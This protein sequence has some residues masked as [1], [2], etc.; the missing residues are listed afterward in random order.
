MGHTSALFV[1]ALLNLLFPTAERHR[2]PRA[3]RRR[4]R[5]RQRRRRMVLWLASWGIDAGPRR[6]HGVRVVA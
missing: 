5:R 6:I 1:R 4:Q 3:E 2:A